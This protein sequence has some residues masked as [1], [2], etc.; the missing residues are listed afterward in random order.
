[1]RTGRFHFDS[2]VSD[3]ALWSR[4]PFLLADLRAPYPHTVVAG[5]PAG[6]IC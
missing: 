4:S 1:M 5:L 6:R 2:I 3:G